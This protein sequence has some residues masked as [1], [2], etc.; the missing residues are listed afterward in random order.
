M[1]VLAVLA[2]LEL[3]KKAHEN[4]NAS[5]TRKKAKQPYEPGSEKITTYLYQSFLFLVSLSLHAQE[6]PGRGKFCKCF[7]AAGFAAGL[8]AARVPGH[9]ELCLL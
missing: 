7:L 5:K 2:L 8:P 3:E 6:A 1:F 9:T 4:E